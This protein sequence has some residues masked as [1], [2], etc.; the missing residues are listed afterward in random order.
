MM[1]HRKLYLHQWSKCTGPAIRQT[2]QRSRWFKPKTGIVFVGRDCHLLSQSRCGRDCLR[3]QL[4]HAA[5]MPHAWSLEGQE[6]E[7]WGRC[8]SEGESWRCPEHTACEKDGNWVG[9]E[10]EDH[11]RW[12]ESSQGACPTNQH[13]KH[14]HNVW[15]LKC[16]AQSWPVAIITTLNCFEFNL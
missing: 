9:K 1:C 13:S 10:D 2:H 3:S 16:S 8:E 11:S 5:C 4:R 15:I 12:L 6:G 7:T 14:E